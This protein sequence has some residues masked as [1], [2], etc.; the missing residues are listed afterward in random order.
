M[1]DRAS[2]GVEGVVAVL[3]LYRAVRRLAGPVAAAASL[4]GRGRIRPPR[5]PT[6]APA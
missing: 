4:V 6:T 2:P 1:G 5:S 3:V